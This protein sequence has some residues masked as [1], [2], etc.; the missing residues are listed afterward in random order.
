MDASYRG[1]SFRRD[2]YL[3]L[4]MTIERHINEVVILDESGNKVA[5]LSHEDAIDAAQ[6]LLDAAG[7]IVDEQEQDA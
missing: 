6:K 5:T 1:Y 4:F 2:I 7:A 3:S